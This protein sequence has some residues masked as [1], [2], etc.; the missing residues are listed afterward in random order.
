MLRHSDAVRGDRAR[1]RAWTADAKAIGRSVRDFDA[2]TW[3]AERAPLVVAGNR[4]K[5]GQAPALRKFLQHT[6]EQ[7]LVEASPRDRIWGIGMGATHDDAEI[8]ARWRG[9]N[10]LGFALMQV[11][12]GL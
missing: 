9:L 10:L 2:A 5:F 8:P 7:I 6:G 1:L 4:A 3:E 11:R 12:D